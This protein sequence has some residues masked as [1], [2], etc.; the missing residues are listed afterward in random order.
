[1]KS[2]VVLQR[3]SGMSS[4]EKAT[5]AFPKSWIMHR[6][7]RG[8][9][10]T[11]SHFQWQRVVWCQAP[12]KSCPQNTNSSGNPWNVPTFTPDSPHQPQTWLPRGNPKPPFRPLSFG[13]C[14]V[15]G[16]SLSPPLPRP[17]IS[18]Q[19]SPWAGVSCWLCVCLYLAAR[20]KVCWFLAERR[21]FAQQGHIQEM[22][23]PTT[24][25]QRRS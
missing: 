24:T 4:G 12:C 21:L 22:G 11:M 13:A 2:H 9:W 20:F 23:S 18:C 17:P 3:K 19:C 16:E 15:F 1:M 10:R 7:T 6:E 8:L 14:L 25:A 5:M